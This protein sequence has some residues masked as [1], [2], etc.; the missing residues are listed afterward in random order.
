MLSLYTLAYAILMLGGVIGLVVVA[1]RFEGV[2]GDEPAPRGEELHPLRYLAVAV[3]AGLLIW[4]SRGWVFSLGRNAL[5]DFWILLP[6]FVV[7][8]FLAWLLF[9]RAPRA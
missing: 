5:M 9:S 3:C 6:L 1:R 8:G 2:V 7:Y 4:M